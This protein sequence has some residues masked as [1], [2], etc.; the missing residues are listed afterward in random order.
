MNN[1]LL[2]EIIKELEKKNRYEDG[3]DGIEGVE[4]GIDDDNGQNGHLIYLQDAIDAVK[5]IISRY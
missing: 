2:N 3:R 5:N 1:F 4:E